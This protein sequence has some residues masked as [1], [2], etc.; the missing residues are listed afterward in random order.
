MA[1][2]INKEIDL[3]EVFFDEDLYPRSSFNWQ[4]AYD[5]TQ[6]MRTGVKF[7][8]IT[9]ALLNKKLYLVDGK[10]RLEATKSLKKTKIEAE[11]FTG[12]TKK[13]IF[14]EAVTRNIAHGRILS[15]Y[16]KRNIALKLRGFGCNEKE[17]SSLIQVPL[18][19]LEHFIGQRLVNSLTGETIIKSE[20]KHIAG[21]N[22]DYS[23][24]LI[25][26]SMHHQNQGRL[27][28]D[29]LNLLEHDLFNR[30]DKKISLLLAKIKSLL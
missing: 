19:K 1:R 10:H 27:L 18:D 15:P 6:S 9:L 14:Q 3:K 2:K 25:Q 22:V 24:E 7:P 17:V 11:V 8:P 13:D 30:E 28:N 21:G 23:V 4:T 26:K 12:W 5:Y 16:E 20:I 29:F